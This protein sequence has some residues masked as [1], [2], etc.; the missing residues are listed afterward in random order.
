MIDEI[1]ETVKDCHKKIIITSEEDLEVAATQGYYLLLN[2]AKSVDVWRNEYGS[3]KK[4]I[5]MDWREKVLRYIA[6]PTIKIS[7]K[8]GT[9]IEYDKK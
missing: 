4:N 2:Y 9:E 5:M 1:N 8:S 3:H 7:Y 6:N